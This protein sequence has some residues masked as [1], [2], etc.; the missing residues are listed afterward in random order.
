MSRHLCICAALVTLCLAAMF[1]IPASADDGGNNP[2]R[3]AV[4]SD[5]SLAQPACG[6]SQAL[7]LGTPAEGAVCSTRSVEPSLEDLLAEPGARLG[8]CHCGC[9]TARCHT[10]ADCGGA[11][12]DPTISCC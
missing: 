8:Y 1:A 7:D 5:L 12:C 11:S 10:S 3:I 6:S 9:T 4:N 2:A